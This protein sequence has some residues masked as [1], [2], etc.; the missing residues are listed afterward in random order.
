[1]VMPSTFYFVPT[2]LNNVEKNTELPR[3]EAI[4]IGNFQFWIKPQLSV[5]SAA[6][7]MDMQRLTR[8]AFIG[9]KIEAEALL[10]ENQRHGPTPA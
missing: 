3:R 5:A 4:I 7:N 9:I 2:R 1:M 8:I 6:G 10:F